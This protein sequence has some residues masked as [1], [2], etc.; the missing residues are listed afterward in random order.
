VKIIK[1]KRYLWRAIE[2]EGEVPESFVTKRRERQA[3]LQSLRRSLKR[4]GHADMIVTDRLASYGA[5][6]KAIGAI[7]TRETGRWL[8]NRA[9]NSR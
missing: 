7:G 9:E 2:H 4:H 1:V 6:L 5:A 3:A 8:N